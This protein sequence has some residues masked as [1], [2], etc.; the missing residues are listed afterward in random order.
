MAFTGRPMRGFLFVDPE[1]IES[2]KALRAW[3]GRCVEF[4]EQKPRK[5]VKPA[6]RKRP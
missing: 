5:A 4:V 2:P 3:V 6:R 1:A